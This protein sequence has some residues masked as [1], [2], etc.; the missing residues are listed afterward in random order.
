MVVEVAA[1]RRCDGQHT[2]EVEACE[3]HVVE[4]WW[5]V[6]EAMAVLRAVEAGAGDD[7]GV[8][9]FERHRHRSPPLE[10]HRQI[11]PSPEQRW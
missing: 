10:M 5:A 7:N 3:T 1:A 11:S 4:A 2:G 6:E 8:L 9:E